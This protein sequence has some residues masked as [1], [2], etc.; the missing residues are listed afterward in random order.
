MPLKTSDTVEE[1]NL[2]LT[3]MIDIVFL[4]I[5]FFMVG[6]QFTARERQ[7]DIDLPTVSAAPPLT[8]APDELVINVAGD[9]SIML[10][11]QEKSLMELE[12]DL[13]A[14][15]Q[16][17]PDQAVVVRGQGAGE[18]QNVMDVLAICHRAKIN[19]IALASQLRLED[20]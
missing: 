2:N 18:Y 9:G 19:N 10:G 20:R 17:Y 1:P 3:P 11:E 6:T 13:H 14:A 7:F 8:S 4:L 12:S 16:N 5:I 15:Q